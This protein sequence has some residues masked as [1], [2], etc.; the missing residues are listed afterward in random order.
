[1]S[2]STT[3]VEEFAFQHSSP[4]SLRQSSLTSPPAPPLEDPRKA[5]FD[6]NISEDPFDDGLKPNDLS[7]LAHDR[8]ISG[9]SS[10][11]SFPASVL[12]HDIERTPPR[13]LHLRHGSTESYSKTPSPRRRGFGS[14]FRNP[15]SIREM[16]LN[17]DTGDD[18]ES[19]VS[20]RS[21]VSVR[22]HGSAYSTNTSPSKRSSRS[23]QKKGSGLKKEFPLVLLHCTLLAPLTAPA[24]DKDLYAA[25]LPEPYRQRWVQLQEKLCSAEL[26]SRGILLPHPQDEYELLEE[27]LLEALELEKPRIQNS[28][29]VDRAAD[30][31]FESG[32]QTDSD[33]A[34]D[35][36]PDCGKHL[37]ANIDK[38]WEIKVYAANG[39]MRGAAW[40][41]AWRDMEKVDVEIA[42]WMPETVRQEVGTRLEAL[43]AAEE[44]AK[45]QQTSEEIQPEQ[46]FYDRSDSQPVQAE[47][48]KPVAAFVQDRRNIAI[49]LLSIMVLVYAVLHA[50]SPVQKRAEKAILPRTAATTVDTSDVTS[51]EVW[52][53][54]SQT[55]D[56]SIRQTHV[57][58]STPSSLVAYD[59][60][61]TLDEKNEH[62]PID[63]KNGVETLDGQEQE[64]PEW[65]T[66]AREEIPNHVEA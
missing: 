66:E 21:R 44:E 28:H 13:S 34:E 61:T 54:T 12:H 30:S 39:L 23:T 45:L 6:Y 8:R 62:G 56:T 14:A 16:Q 53:T 52:T 42:M 5:G 11:S 25:M 65:V 63:Y 46:Q 7:G 22:S 17:D 24:C 19:V 41:A 57:H 49:L 48:P 27:R 59:P 15:S 50:Q 35:K 51:P 31:G 47:L 18:T 33:D 40:S 64:V 58:E 9:R 29:Y 38:K 26:Q 10:I 4:L 55:L 36:C 2:Q 60:A 43:R 20:H 1:M 3:E 32:S 37:R